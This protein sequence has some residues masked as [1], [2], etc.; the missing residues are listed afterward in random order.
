M[1]NFKVA[2]I[3]GGLAG[4]LLGNG[5]LQHDV[6]FAVYESDPADAKREGYQIRLGGPAL[7]GFKVCMTEEQLSKLYP[8][9]GRSGGILSSAPIT[10]DI[11][12]NP[13]L[14]LTKFPAY[15]K[16]APINRIVLVNF[17]SQWLVDA[18]KLQYGKRY[19]GYEILAP[20]E[21]SR[22]KVR[23]HFD[24]GTSNDCDLLISAEGS[25]SKINRQIGLNNIVQLK[26][27]WM[28]LAKGNLPPSK[29][30]NL[31]PEIRKA[32]VGA[33]KNGMMLFISAYLPDGYN[34]PDAVNNQKTREGLDYDSKIASIF[35]CLT[36]PTSSVPG[37]DAKNVSNKLDFCVELI[38]DW[39][40]RFHEML[41]TINNDSITAFQPRTS[42][43]PPRGWRQKASD[44]SDPAKGNDHVWLLGDAFHAMLPGRGMGGNQ[45]MRDTVDMLPRILDLARRAKPDTLQEEDFATAVNKYETTMAPRAF[46]WVKASGGSGEIHV[47]NLDGIKGWLTVFAISRVLDLAYIYGLVLNVFGFGPKDDAP[48]LPN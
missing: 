38:K 23:A 16:S 11:H 36:V 1:G 40:V 20:T 4:C 34:R 8:L 35:W 26:E 42:T 10:Y 9:F 24:D 18:G 6:D 32:P 22:T 3:G 39:D 37:G 12:M 33:F 25:R 47:P 21:T 29:L 31:C 13:L 48:E 45:A 7:E 46:G 5:L 19:V 41:R 14:D 28:F 44:L 27:S 15:T 30:L 17:L 43:E 2:I